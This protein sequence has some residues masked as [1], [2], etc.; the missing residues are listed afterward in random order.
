MSNCG[1]CKGTICSCR[2]QSDQSTTSIVGTGTSFNPFQARLSTPEFR[3]V[4]IITGTDVSGEPLAAGTTE[5]VSFSSSLLPNTSGQMW[6]SG[7]PTRITFPVTGLY[8][9]G[10]IAGVS[11]TAAQAF[12]FWIAKNG[13][14]GS[15][16]VRRTITSGA[17]NNFLMGTESTLYRFTSSDYIELYVQDNINSTLLK[18][19]IASGTMVG[20]FPGPFMWAQWLDE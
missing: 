1:G 20:R 6:N 10:A 9:I 8:F 11:N 5:V 15:P 16:L 17:G 12:H 13:V 18:D 4:E 14:S 19:D 2:V 3:Y 7:A